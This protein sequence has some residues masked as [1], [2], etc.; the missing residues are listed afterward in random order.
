MRMWPW[1]GR[2][3]KVY[4][5]VKAFQQGI[6][7]TVQ[8]SGLFLS[9]ECLF[10]GASLDG[11]VTCLCWWNNYVCEIEVIYHVYTVHVHTDILIPLYVSHTV[12]LLLY[13]QCPYCYK[14]DTLERVVEKSTFCLTETEEGY[15]IMHT[16]VKFVGSLKLLPY[17]IFRCN[18]SCSAHS[19]HTV[20]LWFGLKKKSILK[21]NYTG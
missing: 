19:G 21:N 11:L 1:R 6:W 15:K 2:E 9:L 17:V 10:V 16:T 5:A 12:S 4:P 14:D 13:I 7:S 18:V 20:I 8:E 3:R